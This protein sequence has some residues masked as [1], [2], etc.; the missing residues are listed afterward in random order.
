MEA[1][2][3][4]DGSALF[5]DV[6]KKFFTHHPF[7]ANDLGTKRTLQVADVRNLDVNFLE[8][9]SSHASKVHLA[10]YRR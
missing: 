9:F 8:L 10:F 2:L 6:S 4:G 1:D 5:D 7:F 3:L